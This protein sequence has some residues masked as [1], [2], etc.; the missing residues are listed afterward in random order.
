MKISLLL[1][2][3]VFIAGVSGETVSKNSAA[4]QFPTTVGVKG[5]FSIQSS[6]LSFSY[7]LH[8]GNRAVL[9]L[10]W[11]LPDKAQKGTISIFTVA[12]TKI[13][14]FSITEQH[15]EVSWDIS[16]G[17]KPA[18]GVYLATMTCGTYKTNLQILLSR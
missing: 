18:N 3:A 16:A 4:F 13:R 14:T 9:R 15:G 7:K 17:K 12:G 6:D 11:S 8:S 10:A 5:G 1:L 2:M